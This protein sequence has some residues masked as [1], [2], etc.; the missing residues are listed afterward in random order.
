MK[1][2]CSLIITTESKCLENSLNFASIVIIYDHVEFIRLATGPL[3]LETIA[4]STMTAQ[5]VTFLLEINYT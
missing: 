3:M 4:L 1:V 2:L 5:A